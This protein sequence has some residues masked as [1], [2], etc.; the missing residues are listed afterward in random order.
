MLLLHTIRVSPK[1]MRRLRRNKVWHQHLQVSVLK[2]SRA[3]F[4]ESV[5]CP[6]WRPS[7]SLRTTGQRE[8]THGETD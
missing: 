8:T 2:S 1:D 7:T 3:L 6:F 5:Q 4:V